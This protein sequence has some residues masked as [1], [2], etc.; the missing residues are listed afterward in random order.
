MLTTIEAEI[1]VNGSVTL[2]EP[3]HI[4]KKSRARIILLDDETS[5]KPEMRKAEKTSAAGEQSPALEAERVLRRRQLAW[6]KANR[7]AY[8]GQ[9]VVLD[10]DILL[11]VAQ[12]YPAGRQIAK[13]AN[14]PDAFVTYLSKPDEMGYIGGWD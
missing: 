8:G 11:G 1:D 14:V 9:Y 3:L 6:L 13:Q 7:E 10:G 5:G 12:N 2:L 4:S